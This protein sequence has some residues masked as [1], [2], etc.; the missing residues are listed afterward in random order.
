[1]PQ[2]RQ[3]KKKKSIEKKKCYLMLRFL[4]L[5]IGNNVYN[6]PSIFRE[7]GTFKQTKI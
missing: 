4:F 1:M 2:M 7:M 6:Q 3:I 5:K